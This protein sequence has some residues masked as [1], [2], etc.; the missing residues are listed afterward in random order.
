[1]DHQRMQQ[2]VTEVLF[3]GWAELNQ[4]KLPLCRGGWEYLSLAHPS[5]GRN[6]LDCMTMNNVLNSSMK[7]SW[8]M[9]NYIRRVNRLFSLHPIQNVSN[10]NWCL[11]F[12]PHIW[13]QSKRKLQFM[14][15]WELLD[16]KA[17]YEFAQ[18]FKRHSKEIHSDTKNGIE[19]VNISLFS[20]LIYEPQACGLLLPY[21]KESSYPHQLNIPVKHK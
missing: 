2:R 15:P 4:E 13:Y 16:V 7:R 12:G 9:H 14:N 3:C 11:T 19:D 1:M 21:A 10:T 5:I 17:Q 18:R 8:M 20:Q 6:R